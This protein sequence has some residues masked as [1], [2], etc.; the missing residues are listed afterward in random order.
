MTRPTPLGSAD[1]APT[2]TPPPSRS[3]P[4]PST[5]LPT[6][7]PPS[8]PAATRCWQGLHLSA[9]GRPLTQGFC[10]PGQQQVLVYE[11]RVWGPHQEESL[12]RRACSNLFPAT[13]VGGA[14]PAQ[15]LS[16]WSGPAGWSGLR[17]PS[18]Q[19]ATTPGVPA[20]P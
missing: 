3:G 14:T 10:S 5:V 12:P 19:C 2:G 17:P 4:Q 13:G 15:T 1:T 16:L 6:R 9:C 11:I 18:G 20:C 8:D 7:P